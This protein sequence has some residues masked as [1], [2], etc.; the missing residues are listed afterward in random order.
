MSKFY[1]LDRD[2]FRWIKLRTLRA[3]EPK[4]FS[5]ERVNLKVIA[6]KFILQILHPQGHFTIMYQNP[7]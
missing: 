3:T 6:K 1:P 7:Q 2:L 4:H 5:E